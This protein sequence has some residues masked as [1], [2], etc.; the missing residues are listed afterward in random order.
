MRKLLSISIVFLILSVACKK[1]R[2][3]RL[4]EINYPNFEFQFPAGLSQFQARVFAF[5]VVATDIDNYLQQFSTDTSAIAAI[6]PYFATITNNNN[7]DFDFLQ[8]VSVRACPVGME[9]TAFD[10]V[11][12]LDDLRNRRLSR[13]NLL[14]TL[15]NVKELLSGQNYRLEI[16]FFLSEISP[17]TIDCR[18]E[19]AFEAVR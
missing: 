9:C 19:M 11:F 8:E 7:V 10:E 6:N 5:P 15:R 2:R 12:Y 3:E 18:L 14:P 17:F 4:F 16:V 1:D 13:L